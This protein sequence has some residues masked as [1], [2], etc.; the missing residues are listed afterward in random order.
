MLAQYG[1][2]MRGDLNHAHSPAALGTV[3][4]RRAAQR[5]QKD[6]TRFNCL[7]PHFLPELQTP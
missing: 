7:A 4:L 6:E 3:E 5:C 1:D 2:D